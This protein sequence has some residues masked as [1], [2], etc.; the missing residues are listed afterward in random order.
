MYKVTE[1]ANETHA[2]EI[3]YD[4][5]ITVRDALEGFKPNIKV[6]YAHR[7][8]ILGD[9]EIEGLKQEIPIHIEKVLISDSLSTFSFIVDQKPIKAGI[10]PMNKFVDRDIDD[11]LIR[12]DI[13]SLAE[14]K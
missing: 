8:Y 1:F 7:R 9:V 12:V 2:V 3:Y 14:K 13:I 6:L 11:N 10:D 5:D 4:E